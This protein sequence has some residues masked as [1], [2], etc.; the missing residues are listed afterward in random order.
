MATEIVVP[1]LGESIAEATVAQWLK[2]V[3]DQVEVGD[4]VVELETDK[5][6]LEVNATVA[7][8]ISEIAADTGTEVASVRF[9]VGSATVQPV[10]SRPQSRR[11]KPRH[12][13]HRL[14]SP[15]LPRPHRRPR[16]RPPLRPLFRRLF[17]NWSK[18]TISIL[19]RSQGP[20]RM[21]A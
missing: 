3:G 2:T 7:G 8:V 20:A 10:R 6:T 17:A 15:H 11:R 21:D 19:C 18:K 4:P 14:P 5:V 12:L 1:I 16:R 9:S 13:R